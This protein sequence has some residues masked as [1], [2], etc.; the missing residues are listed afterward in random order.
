MNQAA[1]LDTLGNVRLIVI[2]AERDADTDWIPMQDDLASL[3]TNSA[4]R[5]LPN[6][7]HAMVVEDQT[8]AQLSS[9]AILDVVSSIR[10]HTS[11]TAQK[12]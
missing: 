8:T 10:T 5:T 3:S 12:G 11:I 1:D 6:A 9:Q 2:T 7:T 4:H